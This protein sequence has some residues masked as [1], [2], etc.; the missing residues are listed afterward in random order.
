MY[1]LLMSGNGWG[2]ARDSLSMSRVFEYTDDEISA[3]FLAD[4]KFN[5]DRLA[6]IPAILTSEISEDKAAIAQV[7][8]IHRARI[9]S[10]DVIIEYRI[11]PD[12]PTLTNRDLKEMAD[13]LGISDFE[14]QRTHWAIKDV[15][16]FKVLLRHQYQSKATPRVF[17][18]DENWSI[19][20]KLVSV[21]MP[22][23]VNFDGIYNVLKRTT[24]KLGLDCLRADDI[25]DDPAVIQDVFSLI[26]RSRIVVCDCTGRN[27][28]VFYEAGIAHALGREVIL[29]TQTKQD[30]PFDLQHLRY[31]EYQNNSGG[32]TSLS[33]KLAMK[34]NNVLNNS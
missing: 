6:S 15:D 16:L 12:F 25:W 13:E 9:S 11:E 29:I 10:K 2:K 5:I 4:G 3:E 33:K 22:F 23:N 20:P 31:V 14:F 19:D 27:A 8:V 1:H 21:M 24:K 30:V 26:Y 34:I 28:N 18:I 7:G 17:R 32:R